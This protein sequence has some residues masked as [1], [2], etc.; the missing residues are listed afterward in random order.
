MHPQ[1]R[2]DTKQ[3]LADQLLVERLPDGH[4]ARE[5]LITLI[6]FGVY[7]IAFYRRWRFVTSAQYTEILKEAEAPYAAERPQ[8]D[9][10]EAEPRST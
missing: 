7:R 9:H 4:W 3:V 2:E 8:G 6:F 10:H 1:I 5:T